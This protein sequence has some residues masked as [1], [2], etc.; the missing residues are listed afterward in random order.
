MR[1]NIIQ[2]KLR[3]K[4]SPGVGCPILYVSI[5]TCRWWVIKRDV[6]NFT[7]I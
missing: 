6:A 7:R 2:R 4:N 5:K 3:I 1:K